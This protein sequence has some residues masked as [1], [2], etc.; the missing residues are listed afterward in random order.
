MSNNLYIGAIQVGGLWIGAVQPATGVAYT[1]SA[2]AG[3]FALTGQAATINVSHTLTMSA[4]AFTLTGKADAVSVGRPLTASAGAFALTGRADATSWARNLALGVGTFTVTGEA[5][6]F[7]TG[8]GLAGSA[9][10]FTVTGAALSASAGR[11]LAAGV[12]SFLVTGAQATFTIPGLLV[13]SDRIHQLSTTSGTG[14]LV[15][16]AVPSTKFS[17]A[18]VLNTGDSCY[19]SASSQTLNE[20]EV[21]LFTMRSDGALDRAAVPLKSSNGGAL[22]NFSGSTLDVALDV[23]AKVIGATMVTPGFTVVVR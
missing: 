10:S 1:L 19:G 11:F 22:V 9:G 16:G 7:G 12:G 2:S 4:G 8:K 17:F 21:T 20:V 3:S 5:A 13:W 6:T 23:P 15:L 14:P 18:S